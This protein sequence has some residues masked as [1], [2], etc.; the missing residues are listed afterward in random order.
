MKNNLPLPITNGFYKLDSLPVSAQECTNWYPVKLELPGLSSEILYGTPGAEQVA[1]AGASSTYVNRG[2][3]TFGDQAYFV[4]GTGLYRLT[5]SGGGTYTLSASLGTITG[6]SRVSMAS[7]GTQLMILVP[8]STGYIFTTSPDTL[9][10]ISDVD[11]AANGNPQ[12]V[13]F[14]DGYF[15]CTTDAKKFIISALND[16]LTW[17]ALDVGSAEALPDETVAPVVF[18]NQLFISG[19]GS[20]EGFNNQAVT[21]FPFIRSGQFIERGVKA[22]LTLIN[23]YDA[24]Y[25]IGGGADETPAIW[26]FAGNGLEKISTIAIESLLQGFTADEISSA[27]AWKYAQKGAYFVGFSLP[28]TCLVYEL[29]A[30]KWHERKST[31]TNPDSTV[32]TK[33]WRANSIVAAYGELF[34]GD[35]EDGRIG[36]LDIDIYKEYTEVIQRTVSTQPF[37]NNML[38]FFVASLELTIE[39]GVGNVDATN[40]VL[41]MSR[42]LDGKTWADESLREMGMGVVG[43]YEQRLIW[44]RLG[45][46]KRFE[47]FRF[48]LSD[49][50]KPV[51]IQLTADIRP[52]TK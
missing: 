37:Q 21:D 4:L 38:S 1:T 46:A 49:P 10:T 3:I 24:F 28:T 34:V 45:R 47:S 9:T 29:T 25:F 41:S 42:S 48:K 26:R 20:I 19:S 12:Y 8:G 11:F 39:S 18:L 13:V 30:G 27:F 15:C 31:I 35:S 33:R 51:I 44:R 32:E 52:G 17:D 43:D 16:G 22:P 40:P 14:V 50:V 2:G 23:A 36:R 6:S 7:N 5:D